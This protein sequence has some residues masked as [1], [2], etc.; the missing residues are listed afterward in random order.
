MATVSG[1]VELRAGSEDPVPLA[2]RKDDG[3]TPISLVGISEL[4]LRLEDTAT[5]TVKTFTSPKFVVEN[6]SLGEVKLLQVE[7]DF[8]S[9]TTYL[10]Y[11]TFKDGAGKLHK[12]PE[13]LNY[14]FE[15]TRAF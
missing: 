10:Y 9:Q 7:A 11:V 3:V 14:L 4:T 12:V 1:N 5:G 13:N 2:L 8:P 6:A 15:I